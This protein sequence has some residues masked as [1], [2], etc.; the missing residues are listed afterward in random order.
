MTVARAFPRHALRRCAAAIIVGLVATF[1]GVAGPLPAAHAAAGITLAK[2]G[3]S[4]VLAAAAA[5]YTLTASNTGSAPEYNVT[6]RDVLPV[7]VHYV[8]GTTTPTSAGEPQVITDAVTGAQTLIWSNVTDLQVADSFALG[9][10]ADT[11]PAILPVGATFSNTGSVYANTDPRRI[12]QFSATG[13]PTAG[14]YTE[15]AA[16]TTSPTVVSALKIT[17]SEPSPEAELLRGVHDHPTVYTLTVT[18][19]A[20]SGTTGVVVSDYLPAGLEYLGCG[21]VDNSSAPEYVGAPSLTATPAVTPCVVPA[22]V[23]TVTNPPAQGSTTYPPGVYTRVQ[24]NLGDLA[25]SAVVTLKYAAGI[26]LRANTATFPVGSSTSSVANLDNNTGASTRETATEGGLT[27]IARATGTYTGPLVPGGVAA[28]STDTTHTVSVED[29]RMRKSASSSTF[30]AG[31]QVKYT[32][33]IDVSEYESA[34]GI[35]VTDVLPNGLCPLVTTGVNYATPNGTYCTGQANLL[36]S[37]SV[38]GAAAQPVSATVT[39]QA[40][41]TFKVV[42]SAL[43]GTIPANGTAVLTYWAGMQQVYTAGPHAGDPTASGDSFTNNVALTATTTP[44]SGTGETGT[45]TVADTSSWTLTTDGLTIDKTIGPRS[46]FPLATDPVCGADG[47]GYGEPSSLPAADTRFRKGDLICFKVRANFPS[48]AYTRNPVVTDFLP[49]GTE[50]VAGSAV[51]TSNNRGAPSTLTVAPTLDSLT[52]TIGAASGSG[53]SPDLGAVFEWVFAVRVT[54]AA[55]VGSPDVLGNAMKLRAEDS[56]GRGRSYRDLVDFTIVPAVPIGVIKGVQSID[57]PAAGPNGLN[58]NV[59]GLTVREGSKVTFR[60]DLTNLG[61]AA[62]LTDYSAG[63]FDVWDVLPAGITCADISA[64]TGDATN[65]ATPTIGCTNPG[66]PNQPSFATNGSR[67]A[68]RWIYRPDA[69][70]DPVAQTIAPGQSFTF[71]YVMTIPAPTSEGFVFTNTAAVRS[72]EALTSVPSTRP[73]AVA[74]YFPQNNIDTSVPVADQEAPPA[75][76]TSNVRTPAVDVGKVGVTSV[77]EANN[78]QP[79]QATVGELVTYRYAVTIPAGT[80]V[81]DGSLTDALP[82]GFV[83]QPSP[84]AT[85]EYCPVAPTPTVPDP[86]PACASPGTVPGNISLNPATGALTI[87]GVFDNPTANPARFLVTGT[88]LVTS[89]ALTTAQNNIGRVNTAR[90]T[91][92]D[93][94]GGAAIPPVSKTYTVNVLQPN[95]TIVKT[96]DKPTFVIG[97]QTVTYT[98]SVANRNTDGTTTNRPPLHDAFVVD[99]LP[100]GLTFAAYGANP[101]LTPVAGTGANGCAVGFTRLVWRLGDVPASTT[102]ATRT[103]TATVDL[104]AVGGD[105]YTN[106]A[107]LTGSTLN[108]GKPTFDAPDNPNERVYSRS[109]TSSVTVAGSGLIKTV[110]EPIRTI[111]QV[112]TF[113]ITT[114][115]PPNTNFYGASIIDRVPAGLGTPFNVTYSC[116]DVITNIG[117]GNGGTPLTPAPQADGS[118]LF[119][120]TVGDLL[121]SPNIRRETLVYSATVLDVPSNTAGTTRTNTAT[122]SWYITPGHTPTSA[123]ATFDRSGGTGTATVTVVEPKLSISKQVTDSTP[124]TGQEFRYNVIVANASGATVSDAYNTVVVDHVPLG[125]IVDFIPGG[126]V[127][128]GQDPVRGGG[129][130]TWPASD[131]AGPLLPGDTYNLAYFAH[132]APSSTLDASA[133]V[134][135]ATVQSYESL[136]SAGRVYAG[137]STTASVTPQFPRL[138]TSKVATGGAPAYIG[139]PYTWTVTSTNTGGAEA[140]AVEVSDT[141]PRNW[142]YTTGSARISIN[143][144]AATAKEPTITSILGR[145][146]LRWTS[147]ADLL[148]GEKVTVTYQSTPQSGVV[149]TPGV[150]ATVPHTNTANSFGLDAT[151]ATGNALGDYG[152]QPATASTRIDSADIRIVKGHVG[153]P[154]AGSPFTWTLT[155]SNAGPDTAVGPFTVTDTITA[156]TTFVSASGTGWTCTFA[157]PTVSC[158]RSSPTSTLASGATFPVINVTVAVPADATSGTTLDNSATAGARTYDPLLANNTD[159]DTATVTTSADLAI[160]KSHTGT[161]LAGQDATYTLDVVNYGPSVSRHDITVVDTLPTGSTFVSSSGLGWSACLVN[162]PSAGRISC[163]R[164]ADL[165]PG[166]AAPQLVVVVSVPSSQTAQ[167]V[168]TA[169]VSGATPDPNLANNTDDDRATPS[170]SADLSIQKANIGSVVAGTTATYRL[171]V[172]NTGPSDAAASVRITDTLPTG[173]TYAGFTSRTGT[174]SC[175]A[176]AQVVTCDLSGSLAADPDGLVSGDAIVDIAVD[177]ASNVTGT[178]VNTA[179][180]SSPTPDPNLTNN[181][182]IDSSA[183]VGEADLQI[184]KSHTGNAVAGNPFTWTLAV[185]NN[186]PSDSPGN[187]VV[188]DAL[189]VGTTYVSAG[190]TGWVCGAVG[191]L[192]TCTRSATLVS[193]TTDAV[194]AI[195]PPISLVVL[196]DASAGPAVLTNIAS[197]DGPVVDPVPGN[198]VDTDRVTVEDQADVTILKQRN[199]P[200]DVAAGGTTS[201][202]LT[203]TNNGPST[204]DSLVVSDTL[205]AGLVPVSVAGAGW[206]CATPIGQLVRCTRDSQLPSTVAAPSSTLEID[207]RVDSS[208]A[209]GTTLVNTATVSTSTPGDDL[210]NNSSSAPVHVVAQ[211]DLVLVKTHA[212]S[213]DRPAAGTEVV[214]DIAVSNAGP[215]DAQPDVR[216]V[217]TLPVG[218]AYV[219]STGPWTCS[220]AAPTSSGQ[221]VTCVLDGGAALVAGRAAP[222]LAIRAFLAA[223]LDTGVLTNSATVSSPTTDLVPDNN[224]DTDPVRVTQSADL[225]IAKTHVGSAHIG[226][227]LAY[228]LTVTNHGPSQARQVSVTDALPASLT[229]VSAAGSGWTCAEAAVTVTVTCDLTGPLA[230]GATAEP[231]TVT[232]TVLAA[233][234]PSVTNSASV[235]ATTPDPVSTN[236]ADSDTV[237]V[238]ALVD[239]TVTKSHPGPVQ[240]GSRASYSLVV[241]NHGPTADPGPQTV[242]DTLPTGL[243]FLSGTGSGWACTAVGQSVT[244]VHTGALAVGATATLT[245]TVAV[246]PSAFPGV[247][248]TATVSTPS[249]ETDVTNNTA[250]D[251]TAVAP[252]VELALVKRLGSYD[253]T[254]QLATWV[255]AVTND[256]PNVSQAPIVVV[257]VL[258]AGLTYVSAAGPGWSCGVNGQTVTCTHVGQVPVGATVAFELDSR[259]SAADGT[260]ITNEA[261]LTGHVD[262]HPINDKATAT[263]T[264]P[265]TGGLVHTGADAASLLLLALMSLM[266]GGVLLAAGR[267]RRPES[268]SAS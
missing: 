45:Q 256:G 265:N 186:G 159:T 200:L 227:P 18:N 51:A 4:S 236:N 201:F 178:I 246:L 53:L 3:P 2:S 84:I 219:S 177:V 148:P 184:V 64:I 255:I 136:P 170:A 249:E 260:V 58:S 242:V 121:S 36:P 56:S 74:T 35:V 189:P 214:Y 11:D 124:D 174:W 143:G 122:S 101:G 14:S 66:D 78:N 250:T 245:L 111:G 123:G 73:G 80:A 115:I 232:V 162:T 179:T 147:L 103:Y 59:D 31:G 91:S 175:S 198:N 182:D 75:S 138:A 221:A 224:T 48:T 262:H 145:S 154:V 29:V 202:T 149:T 129:T 237:P 135:T 16:A 71:T 32:V 13:T 152:D 110:D 67:S 217:D 137:P 85:V 190:G 238:P 193:A 259:V 97:G 243:G 27:N 268:G 209:D 100:V 24:W 213:Y 50:Y 252:L 1:V 234:Y 86:L 257:D 207:V 183:F 204:A 61:S 233:A 72:Y 203:V 42:F 150:G 55:P 153:T 146:V 263:L 253:T 161:I 118:T 20:V 57:A 197:V 171:T 131:L 46:A 44:I 99:C 192:V 77:T 164:T 104:S 92:V 94:P 211:A 116:V 28:T 41:G 127:L 180:V 81:F 113:T 156:P 39:T 63:A 96:N 225:A 215:S 117:C 267:R 17:K 216:V 33:T 141:L 22:S 244:C 12:P 10:S 109:D 70:L 105:T 194:A 181:T 142:V 151:D 68:I 195:A 89:G 165:A 173:L 82:T 231:I 26:P 65:P 222:A 208:V 220:A 37:A 133:L 87:A 62:G 155:V 196:V 54:D 83:L 172:D 119:G 7:G 21:G 130:I 40:D 235:S 205:P 191:Q 126:G 102:P 69:A 52:W 132:L 60:V 93:S 38:N 108:D 23:T 15:T 120:F 185:T 199:G 157:S 239:L 176:S 241:T 230:P 144:A 168:N 9:F 19:T 95:P 125:V 49:V 76:D 47:S 218:L 163:T 167:V 160:T 6:F 254:T 247:T 261:F 128:T 25:A 166:I 98:V 106:T 188:T 114:A 43:S 30:Q 34:S 212:H 223:D 187:I 264:I 210:S 8:G 248:N 140:F 158:T 112:A 229:Y 240:V 251:P 266:V 226:S 79:N 206:T 134:N 139:T 5:A 169:T 258:P 90:F 88:V 107:T 228:T